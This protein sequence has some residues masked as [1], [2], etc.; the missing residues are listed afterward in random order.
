MRNTIIIALL[1][2]LLLNA[3]STESKQKEA[4][5]N[6]PET[7]ALSWL[8]HYYNNRFDEATLLSTDKTKIMIDTIKEVVF[9]D[10]EAS[11]SFKISDLICTT[12]NDTAFCN[13]LYQEGDLEM[14]DEL[15]L[16]KLKDQWLVD[17][18]LRSNDEL[19]EEEVEKIFK[20]FEEVLDEEL[21][22]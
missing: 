16:L 21:D 7:V 4:L 5:P 14:E 20:E 13:F 1:L 11:V 18:E 12:K 19:L 3:C 9:T 17:A 10:A 6:T 22:L 8:E 15:L 2:M